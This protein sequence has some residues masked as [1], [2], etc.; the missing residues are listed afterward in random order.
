M[1]KRW[2]LGGLVLVLALALSACGGATNNAQQGEQAEGQQE[3]AQTGEPVTLK[4]G[5]T[6]VPH[7]EILE[8][9]VKPALEKE[10]INL[11]VV[12]YEDYVQPN[13]NLEDGEIDA[14]YFQH[15][16]YLEQMV[17]ERNLHL[18]PLVGV[19]IEPMGVYSK[20]ITSLDELA[21]GATVTIPDD[22]TNGGR[23][24]L[25]LE[26]A[27]LLK[28]KEDAGIEA[29]VNDIAENPK[30]LNIKTLEA[31]MLPRTLDDADIAVINTNYAME[32]G[33]V[34]TK[35][36]LFIEESDSPYV[37]I[38][39]VREEDKD[40]ENLAKLAKALISD[41]VKAYIEEKY[42]GAVVPAFKE[43]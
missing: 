31:A 22:P 20:K 12:V 1:L 28:L 43:F 23:A 29:T 39:V 42:E 15:V 30:N 6:A 34:P 26:K 27:G 9:V 38:L 3:A 41:E 21:D 16:P 7:A 13:L 17:S 32:A 36:A 25:L 33:L 35:D 8:D 24:L 4:V 19:H 18:V 2:F 11:E 14:N 37:N 40:D 10:G 5:A